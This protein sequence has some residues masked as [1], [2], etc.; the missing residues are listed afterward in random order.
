MHPAASARPA[1]A[2]RKQDGTERGLHSGIVWLYVHPMLAS[3]I[4]S[5]LLRPAGL[6]TPGPSG[7]ILDVE[8][9]VA[10]LRQYAAAVESAC[11][12]DPEPMRIK[13][14]HTLGVLGNAKTIAAEERFFPPLARAC[15]LAAVYHDVARYEQY[16]L[17]NTFRDRDSMS[18]GELGAILVGTLGVLEREPQL[19]RAV[20]EAVRLHN[21]YA[22]PEELPA[23]VRIVTQTVRDADKLDIM[24]VIDAH[25]SRP[26]P[27]SPTVVLSRPDDPSLFSD[28]VIQACLDHRAASYD[29]LASVNDFR[30]LLGTWIYGL[31]YKASRRLLARQGRCRRL[32]EALPADGPY[33]EARSQLLD[34]L[35]RLEAE[36]AV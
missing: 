23:D 26:G 7:H 33:R 11:E 14:A 20:T 19:A 2:E 5:R 1:G 28:K 9:H 10:W 27:Y 16:R 17:W 21:A 8:A 15:L 18:H 29:D 6:P 22:L 30:L 32:V 13:T 35:A 31:N 34:E 25:L 4:E 36:D 3:E 12:G 24:R